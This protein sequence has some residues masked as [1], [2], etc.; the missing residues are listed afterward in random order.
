MRAAADQQRL[1]YRREQL[2]SYTSYPV[3]AEE[4]T[5]LSQPAPSLRKPG[6][7]ESTQLGRL[8]PP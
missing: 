3:Y 7:G 5:R 8:A 2:C 1:S 4:N 6:N